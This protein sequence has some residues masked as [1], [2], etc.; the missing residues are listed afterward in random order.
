M[1]SHQI[2]LFLTDVPPDS[3]GPFTRNPWCRR[4]GKHCRQCFRQT[5]EA[6][7]FNAE[8]YFVEAFRLAGLARGRTMAQRRPGWWRNN[9]KILARQ[10]RHNHGITDAEYQ[11][12]REAQG[13]V[14]ALC[15][16]PEI[17]RI[18]GTLLSLAVDHDHVTGQIRG[19]LCMKCNHALGYLERYGPGWVAKVWRYLERAKNVT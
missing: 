6:Y 12:M 9:P 13:G 18:K 5:L 11:A 16:Q 8:G 3:S 14:C 15:G 7:G 1:A 10:R 19:L 4:N 17:H 2:K